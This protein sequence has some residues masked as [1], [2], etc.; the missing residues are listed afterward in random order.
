MTLVLL[1]QVTAQ[2]DSDVNTLKV[3]V[4]PA[5]G[6]HITNRQSRYVT[7]TRLKSAHYSLHNN[8]TSSRKLLKMDVLTSE[9]C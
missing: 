4:Q 2:H 5:L 6:Y 1:C 9:T 7:P 8:A 3:V